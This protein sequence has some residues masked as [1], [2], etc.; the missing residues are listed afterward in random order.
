MFKLLFTSVMA[1][2]CNTRP[3]ATFKNENSGLCVVLQ[4][5]F[6]SC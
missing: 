5:H 4:E 3:D 1:V 6:Y 2:L